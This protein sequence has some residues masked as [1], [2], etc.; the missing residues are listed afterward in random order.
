LW[1]EVS[2]MAGMAERSSNPASD[3]VFPSAGS[4]SRGLK[5]HPLQGVHRDPLAFGTAGEKLA[6]A[7]R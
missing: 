2:D 4:G 3:G 1:T 7:A 6:A 5:P